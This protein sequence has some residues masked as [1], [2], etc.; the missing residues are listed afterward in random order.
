MTRL[1]SL[2]AALIVVTPLLIA[3]LAQATRIFV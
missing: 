3:T 1:A 2:T